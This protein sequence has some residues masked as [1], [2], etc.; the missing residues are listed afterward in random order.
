MHK[1]LVLALLASFTLVAC[2]NEPDKSA[3]PMGA[4]KQPWAEFAA[5]TIDEYYRRN[6]ASAVNEGLHQY[7]GQVADQSMAAIEEY[8]SWIDS[9]L[10]EAASYTGLEGVEAFERDY[11]STSLN[12]SLFWLRDAEYPVKNPL[13]YLRSMGVSVYVDRE[14]APLDQRLRA[15]TQHMEQVPGLLQQMQTNLQPPLP[16]PY[17][18]MAGRILGGYVEYFSTTVPEIFSAAE[19]EQLHRQFEAAN[20]AAIESIE[21]VVGWLDGLKATATDD[22]ALGEERFLKM[23]RTSQGV[24]VTLAELKAAGQKNLDDNLQMLYEACAEFAP[25]ESTRDCMTKAAAN[26]PEGGAVARAREQLPML[27]KFVEDNQIASIPG[28]ENALVDE[29]P[30]HRR[31]NFAYINIPG[32]FESGLPSTYFIAPPDPEWSEE[33]QLAYIPGEA[34]LLAVS[35]HEVWPGHFLQYLHSNRA[36]NN[37]GQHFGTYTFSEGWAHYTEQMMV[38]AGLGDGDPEIRIGQ[39][40]NALLR[41]VRYMSAIGLHTEGMTIEESQTMFE[42]KAFKDFGN[43]SQQAYRGT[44]DPGYLNYTLGKLMINKLRDDW[45]AGKGGREA[46]GRFHDQFLSYGQPPIPLI[47]EQM[48][49]EDYAGD[50]S[51]LPN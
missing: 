34:D 30:P 3:A 15:Y 27:R 8:A 41:N 18:A 51:I 21:R 40:Q 46:W 12:G 19:D 26:K 43:A 38:D 13:Y 39:L 44:Y 47:R 42:E 28:T 37:V 22:F 32:S 24:D 36:E 49:G 7:D 1:N 10:T 14:Y 5:T 11:M 6:P 23:L 31:F 35:V 9:V 48:L 45:T 29:A 16:A 33:D 17:V 4:A 50:D 20:D 2:S 25:G